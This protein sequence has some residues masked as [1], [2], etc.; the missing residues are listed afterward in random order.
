M[1][2]QSTSEIEGCTPTARVIVGDTEVPWVTDDEGNGGV[3]V[4]MRKSGPS[5]LTRFADVHIPYEWYG[6]DVLDA[7]TVPQRPS[8]P[9]STQTFNNDPVRIDIFDDVL[10]QYITVH[11]GPIA[12]SGGSTLDGCFRLEI[13]DWANY[14]ES[15]SADVE[16]QAPDIQDVFRYINQ[17]A[18]E[19]SGLPEFETVIANG[20]NKQ[21]LPT[22]EE[23]KREAAVVQDLTD[24][25]DI[26]LALR[27]D[28]LGRFYDE[29]PNNDPIES[30]RAF[31]EYK[32][33]IADVINWMSE[34]VEDSRWY[35]DYN[36]E[37]NRPAIVFD[38]NPTSPSL[39]GYELT[40]DVDNGVR[41]RKNNALFQISPMHTLGVRGKKITL[42]E[43]NENRRKPA[44][45]K[46][47]KGRH[48]VVVEHEALADRAGTNDAP[49]FE[50]ADT[51]TMAETK[52]AAK[53]RLK[54]KIDGAAGGEMIANP[55]GLVR[56]YVTIDAKPTCGDRINRDV[57]KISY[58]IEEVIHDIT[59]PTVKNDGPKTII[60][61]GITVNDSD[62]RV[63]SERSIEI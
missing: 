17:R 28:K 57:D 3:E 39:E 7:I 20:G 31:S 55:S 50:N 5:N 24:P 26:L 12:A 19:H 33:N 6:D 53:K 4:Q 37:E 14:F 48:E 35:V 40:K 32:H 21:F 18:A 47:G 51:T 9:R 44:Y 41:L 63:V 1:P 42:K 60:R 52:K 34:R 11:H 46:V 15:I 45:T 59:A 49:L 56:P 61:C 36:T 30:G 27:V 2:L 25:S 62:I 13:T 54:N 58:E 38:L 29:N 16:F 23:A 43:R 8:D 22:K 10:E